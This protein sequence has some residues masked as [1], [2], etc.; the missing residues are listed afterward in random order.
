MQ[1][2]G[3]AFSGHD[4]DGRPVEALI[5][6]ASAGGVSVVVATWVTQQAHTSRNGI[7]TPFDALVSA[8]A[9]L[10]TFR[11]PFELSTPASRIGR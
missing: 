1:G 10:E 9:L 4:I 8:D 6:A 5:E 11:W 3:E 2:L 7:A